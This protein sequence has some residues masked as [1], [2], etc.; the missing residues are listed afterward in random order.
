MEY[1]VGG[2]FINSFL[3][4]FTSAFYLIRYKLAMFYEA[5]LCDLL[6][7]SCS[8][9]PLEE[10]I[11][12]IF[13]LL[14]INRRD[15]NWLR[16]ETKCVSELEWIV[17]YAQ[18]WRARFH[19]HNYWDT[20]NVTDFHILFWKHAILKTRFNWLLSFTFINNFGFNFVSKH[21][22]NAMNDD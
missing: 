9:F 11:F 20:H 12:H 10:N 19:S 22:H 8:S 1:R 6:W 18:I 7:Q 4:I 16:N 14:F 3:Q 13:R 2:L 15:I 17:I 21:E 5:K